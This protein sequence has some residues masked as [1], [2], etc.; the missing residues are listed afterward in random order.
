LTGIL[1]AY[2]GNTSP[3]LAF[4]AHAVEI[5]TSIIVAMNTKNK[6]VFATPAA[7]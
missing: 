6:S 1:K 3:M 5:I 7:A 4:Q 2:A